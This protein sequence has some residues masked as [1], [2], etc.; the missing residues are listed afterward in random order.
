LTLEVDSVT[1]NKDNPYFRGEG[2]YV[3]GGLRI[4]NL[5]FISDRQ[6]GE[7]EPKQAI[8]EVRTDAWHHWLRAS[9]EACEAC[10]QARAETIGTD[11]EAFQLVLEHEFR[12][13][14][15]AICGS[16]FAIDAFYACV[17]EHAPD[18]RL[19]A[20]TRVKTIFTTLTR[21]FVFTNA[22]QKVGDDLSARSSGSGTGPF[23]LRRNS[24]DPSDTRP[25]DLGWTRAS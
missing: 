21:A 24:S 15:Q 14:M 17:A 18:A 1:A 10:A 2:V 19:E 8:A 23:I 16:A 12:A 13:G 20:A 7:V 5:G 11:D 3:T 9:K 25:S 4:R 6:T 22:Q